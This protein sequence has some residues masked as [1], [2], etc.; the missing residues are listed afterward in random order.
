MAKIFPDHYFIL[1]ATSEREVGRES[2]DSGFMEAHWIQEQRSVAGVIFSGA[3]C[4]SFGHQ[5]ME[6]CGWLGRG[7]VSECRRIL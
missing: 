7:L 1:A 2:E 4:R 5:A 3:A 6:N